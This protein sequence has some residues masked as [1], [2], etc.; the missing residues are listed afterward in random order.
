MTGHPASAAPAPAIARRSPSTRHAGSA[1]A[2]AATALALAFSAAH[3]AEPKLGPYVGAGGGVARFDSDIPDQIRSAYAGTGFTVDSANIT[4]NE[5][6]AWKIYA[7]WRLHRYFAVE[8]GYL[9]LGEAR[10][11]Y[12]VGVPGQGVAQRA[13]RYRLDGIELAALGM[14]PV[15]ERATVFAKAGVLFSNLEY[16]ESGTDQS[17]APASFS[18]RTRQQP[19]LWGVGGS[20]QFTEAL[21]ARLEWQ[22]VEDVGRNFALTDSGNGKFSHVD[23]IGLNLQWQF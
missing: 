20:W 14:L 19:F 10:S 6:G 1:V 21:S 7:G 2:V 17:G 15:G 5:E 4:D 13:G 3:A 22:R 8:V 12:D 9:D 11:S 23:V 18:H 16:S